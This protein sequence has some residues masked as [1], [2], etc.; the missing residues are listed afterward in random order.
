[1]L[2]RPV[3]QVL[4]VCGK[5][6]GTDCR[7]RCRCS[8]GRRI[9]N[10]HSFIRSQIRFSCRNIPGELDR[11]AEYGCTTFR[12]IPFGTAGWLAPLAFLGGHISDR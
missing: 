1:M 8:G 2:L 6:V 10:L 11:G 9:A 12:K 5:K 3:K 7:R 4:N